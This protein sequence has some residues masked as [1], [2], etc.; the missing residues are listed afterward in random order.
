MATLPSCWEY[1][2]DICIKLLPLALVRTI[3]VNMDSAVSSLRVTQTFVSLFFIKGLN[4][5]ANM[6][7]CSALIL[8]FGVDV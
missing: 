8:M 6:R 2:L 3:S 4:E 7:F 5:L 1:M